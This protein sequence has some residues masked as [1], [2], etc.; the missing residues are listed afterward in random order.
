MKRTSLLSAVPILSL[1]FAVSAWAAPAG[2][3]QNASGFVVI[4]SNKAAPKIAVAGAAIEP[5]TTVR[6]GDR[7]NAVLRFADG[8]LVAL[9]ENSTF[10]LDRYAFDR[11]APEQGV[12]VGS[13]PRGTARFVTGAIGD[14]NKAGWRV[15]MPTANVGIQGTDLILGIQ[16]GGYVQV[17]EGQVTLTNNAGTTVFS[18]GEIGYAS[19]ANVLAGTIAELPAAIATSFGNQMAVSLTA[20]GGSAAGAGIAGGVAGIPIPA[21]GLI[22][23]GIAGAAAAAG[24]SSSGG[25]VP[26]TTHH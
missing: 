15:S 21:W 24:G 26:T 1:L 6:T 5:G 8:Q 23:L 10:R 11:A 25:A 12:F 20:S 2:Q 9:N 17:L 16:Q 4:E 18:A 13:L 19:S 14:N 22:G 3:V 7:S